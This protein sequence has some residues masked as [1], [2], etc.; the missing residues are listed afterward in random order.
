[1]RSRGGAALPTF[2]I[3]AL[4]CVACTQ[5]GLAGLAARSFSESASCPADRVA[6]AAATFAMSELEPALGGAPPADVASDPAR[7]ALWNKSQ[8][9][10]SSNYEEPAAFLVSGCGQSTR[11][12]CY[13]AFAD[14]DD[15][16]HPFCFPR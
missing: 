2:V 3:A 8:E 12:I 10:A 1:M 6:V 13:R 9:K 14:V 5:P 16:H 7:L 15:A 4:A 11:Y